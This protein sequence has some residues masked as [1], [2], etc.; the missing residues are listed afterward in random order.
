M[1]DIVLESL[2]GIGL[3]SSAGLNAYIPLLIVGLLGRFTDVI[4]LPASFRWL[5]NPWVIGIVTILFAIEF[6]AD[7]IPIVDHV[8]DAIQTVVRPTSGGL[9]FGAASGSQTATVTDP[10]DFFTNNQWVPIVAG[11]V[12]SFIVHSM[13]AAARPVINA[14]TAGVGAPVVSTAEDFVSALMSVVAILLPFL[15]I[16]FILGMVG[17]FVLV[18]R[19][20]RRRKE[21]K[22]ARKA[23]AVAAREGYHDGR[24]LDIRR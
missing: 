17:F 13:K 20:R 11:I 5:E 8:N 14:S 21:A 23:A 3:A 7:K 24:T 9:V 12:I 2:M 10:A 22:A 1:L 19:W 16:F 18:R 15:I 6:V 4:D